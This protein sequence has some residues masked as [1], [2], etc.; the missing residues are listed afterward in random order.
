[1][2]QLSPT[3][4]LTAKVLLKNTLQMYNKSSLTNNGTMTC[5]LK[6][7]ERSAGTENRSAFRYHTFGK[8]RP[9][10]PAGPIQNIK[11][12]TLTAAH[13]TTTTTVAFALWLLS[14]VLTPLCLNNNSFRSV[15]QL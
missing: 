1:M 8:N 6:T 9:F 15:L 2:A 3:K 5:T 4:P 10:R 11:Y 13:Y 7:G 12:W 14:S